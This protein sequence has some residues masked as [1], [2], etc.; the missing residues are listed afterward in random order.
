MTTAGTT[1]LK[2]LRFDYAGNKNVSLDTDSGKNFALQVLYSKFNLTFPTGI[3]WYDVFP[4][5]KDAKEV[6]ENVFFVVDLYCKFTAQ[7]T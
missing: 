1:I 3:Y 4:A 2:D 7:S 5:S 6:G